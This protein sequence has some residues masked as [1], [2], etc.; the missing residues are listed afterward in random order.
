MDLQL[1]TIM[2]LDTDHLEEI[3]QDIRYQYENGTA[4]CALFIM[5]L[6][7]EGNPPVDKVGVLC[8]KYDLF[9]DRLREMGLGS[10][11]LVQA[12]IGHGWVLSEMFPF[13]QYTG[14]DNGAVQQIVCPMDPGFG[15]YVEHVFATIAAHDPDTI[16]LDDDFRL[17]SARNGNGCACPL[18]MEAFNRLAGTNFTREE[19]SQALRR[20][21]AE[22][23][24]YN[25]IMIRIQKD[26]LINCARRMRDGIDS[27]NP[28]LPGSFC[29]VGNNVECAVEI[30]EIMAGKGNPTVVLI[31]NGNYTAAGAR[32]FSN[33]FLRAAQSIAKLEGKVDMIL[34]ETDTCP[35]NRYS[36][37][38]MSLHTHFTGTL[39]EGAKGAKHW[40]TRLSAFEPESGTA[41]RR[42]LGRNAGFYRTLADLTPLLKWR[43]CRI[44]TSDTPCFDYRKN[45]SGTNGWSEC[46]LE[47]L[48]LPMYF[49][50][51]AGGVTCLEGSVD[52]AFDDNTI[53][54]M[55]SG[56]VFLASDAAMRLIDRG[57]GDLLGVDV[58][59]WKGAQPSREYLPYR[60]NPANVQVRYK[61]LVPLSADTVE[62]SVVYHTVD[63]VHKEKLFPGSTIYKNKNGGIV[64]TFCGTPRTNYNLVE[65]FSFL[66]HSR[67]MQLI[68][69]MKMAGELPVYYPE[70]AEVYLRAAD[71]ADGR[72][73]CAVFNIGLDPID[74]LTLAAEKP[75]TKIEKLMPDGSFR[76]IGFTKDE[77]GILTLDTPAGVLDPVILILS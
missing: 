53:A 77:N 73:F 68:D 64:F 40:I 57:F 7:P 19:L 22:G 35:Q 1:Y 54:E 37:G 33:V 56:P 46:V 51:K 52:G 39:L 67:K 28:A 6:V 36:T 2:P 15:D 72:L 23:D 20:H 49:S 50:P 16:M 21:D 31:N 25:E 43:G 48:G 34:A 3:C 38:A 70:D 14:L 10:G 58:R 63:G 60:N 9:R 27:V 5:T 45:N 18:H 17:M 47:R 4:T 13:Q 30:A 59:E 74:V 75:V 69:M 44:P 11:V 29:C 71:M 8:Q 61:E 32:F 66:N 76:E 12:T 24:R 41:Y 55:L 65:A 26:A 42:I 62:N